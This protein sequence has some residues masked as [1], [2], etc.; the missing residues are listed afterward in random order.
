VTPTRLLD[1]VTRLGEAFRERGMDE[2]VRRLRLFWLA[3]KHGLLKGRNE[4][5]VRWSEAHVIDW[6]KTLRLPP[7]EQTLPLRAQGQGCPTCPPEPGQ[8]PSGRVEL[9]FPEGTRLRCESCGAQWLE[10]DP[11]GRP[12]V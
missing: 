6:M 1:L 3:A 9:V 2:Q 8:V 12:R 11:R 10:L 5:D 4:L 7:F